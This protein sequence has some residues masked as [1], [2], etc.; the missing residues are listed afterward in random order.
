M[1]TRTRTISSV[2]SQESLSDEPLGLPSSRNMLHRPKHIALSVGTHTDSFEIKILKPKDIPRI[3][4][5]RNY[6]YHA[7]EW[8]S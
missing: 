4:Q 3:E 1:R 8:P 7:S 2:E 5:I 6:V